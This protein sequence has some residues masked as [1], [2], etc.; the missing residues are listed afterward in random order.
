MTASKESRAVYVVAI[1]LLALCGLLLATRPP[2][3]PGGGG[4]GAPVQ[5]VLLPGTVVVDADGGAGQSR[6]VTPGPP[7]TT[8]PQPP[9][10]RLVA[11]PTSPP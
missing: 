11:S 8:E 1:G 9:T 2:N 10:G 4:G 5:Y 6:G 7:A 3:G